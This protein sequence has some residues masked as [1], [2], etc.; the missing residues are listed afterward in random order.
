MSDHTYSDRTLAHVEITGIDPIRHTAWFDNTPPPELA[1]ILSVGD[2]LDI[3]SK[4]TRIVGWR[5]QGT[6]W[7][8]KSDQ[9]L[10]RE[11]AEH[12][13]A[14]ERESA[15]RLEANRDDWERRTA[16]LP[17]WIQPRIRHF[18]DPAVSDYCRD[19]GITGNQH[20]MARALAR[21]H[22][23]DPERSLAGTVSALAPITG[24]QDYSGENSTD[25]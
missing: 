13:D 18:M 12:R 4:G 11:H 3:E 15:E 10:E 20:G 6:W 1:A 17:D 2:E 9:D 21:A 23:E 22:H 8:R 19:G 24:D 5:F 25:G 16:A 14:V 7:D